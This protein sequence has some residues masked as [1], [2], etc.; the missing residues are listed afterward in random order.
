[1]QVKIRVA[2]TTICAAVLVPAALI[3]QEP[4]QPM[5]PDDI[6]RRVAALLRYGA[7]EVPHQMA[8]LDHP[9]AELMAKVASGKALT[10]AESALYRK[11]VQGVLADSQTL[12]AILDNNIIFA[13]D[14]GPN[15][16]NNCG[17]QGISGRHD[18]HAA[19]A[20]SNFAELEASLT[21]LQTAGFLARIRHANRAYKSLTDLMVH[22]A[23]A[24]ASVM[25]AAQPPLPPN[26]DPARAATFD[27]FRL[28][29]TKAGFAPINSPDHR[30]ALTTAQTAFADLSLSVQSAVTAQLSPLEQRIA[31]RWLSLQSVSPR[32]GAM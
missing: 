29:M 18:L 3:W 8:G 20:V 1:M 24:Q 15:D 2:I 21:A 19:S 22:L 26:A 13:S 14:T 16:P 30:A 12:F 17:G 25:L 6:A 11:A 10:A 4:W 28:A 7:V 9:A 5:P 23:P 27:A 31:G 32:L